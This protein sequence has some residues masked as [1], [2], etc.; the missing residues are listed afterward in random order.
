MA[1]VAR[2][3]RGKNEADPV[4][5]EAAARAKMAA[6]KK[7]A[8]EK[9][10]IRGEPDAITPVWGQG[11][12]HSARPLSLRTLQQPAATDLHAPRLSRK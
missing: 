10:A 11:G 2:L 7:A 8:E 1:A 6:E 9:A 12:V 3:V 4:E 5:L